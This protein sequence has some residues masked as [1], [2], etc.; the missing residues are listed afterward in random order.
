MSYSDRRVSLC[1]FSPTSIGYFN[2]E[3]GRL[4]NDREFISRSLTTKDPIIADGVICDNCKKL[5]DFIPD[6]NTDNQAMEMTI[7]RYKD[8]DL[9]Y[10]DVQDILIGQFKG[11]LLELFARIHELKFGKVLDN[12][13]QV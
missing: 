5:C 11:S 6:F 9:K 2:T 12:N 10:E 1:C 4:T 13:E 7:R 3:T 8:G